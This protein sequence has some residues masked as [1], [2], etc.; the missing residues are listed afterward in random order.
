MNVNMYL[1]PARKT[2]VR[3]ETPVALHTVYGGTVETAL[4]LVN[5]GAKGYTDVTV[6]A[7]GVPSGMTIQFALADSDEWFDVLNIGALDAYCIGSFMTQI[8]RA[9]TLLPASERFGEL[10]TKPDTSSIKYVV[11]GIE[12]I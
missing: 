5:T 3:D 9:I 7:T 12:V 2:D 4:F 6:E 8:K 1:D 11:D 10:I